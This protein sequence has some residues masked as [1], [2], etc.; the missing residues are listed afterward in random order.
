MS[1][2]APGAGRCD[3]VVWFDLDTVIMN[4]RRSLQSFVFS[5]NDEIINPSVDEEMYVKILFLI[6]FLF[7][8]L[9][10]FFSIMFMRV[11]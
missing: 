2:L 5:F 4:T 10:L 6:S 11:Y 8:I 7:F 3:W 1:Y 9:F